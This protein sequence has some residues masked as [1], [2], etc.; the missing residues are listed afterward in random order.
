MHK[1]FSAVVLMMLASLVQADVY[2]WVDRNGIVHY[3]DTPPANARARSVDLRFAGSATTVDVNSCCVAKEDPPKLAAQPVYIFFP[4]EPAAPNQAPRGLDFGVYIM[5]R[6][7]MSEGELLQR[8]GPPDFES[9]D[10]NSVQAFAPSRRGRP[11][12]HLHGRHGRGLVIPYGFSNLIVKTFYYYP[13][14]SNPFTT[15]LTLVGGRIS[16]LQRTRQF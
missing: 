5:L 14:L 9:T 7:G 2:K 1:S 4:P 11:I 6:R 3:G 8:A 10:G 12:H 13:T 16:D 15:E